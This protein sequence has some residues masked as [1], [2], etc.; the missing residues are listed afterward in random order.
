M[1]PVCESDVHFHTHNGTVNTA[2]SSEVYA[3]KTFLIDAYA[4]RFNGRVRGSSDLTSK[5][6]GLHPHPSKVRICSVELLPLVVKGK[7]IFF[8]DAFVKQ[9]E[10]SRNGDPGR[11]LL[12]RLRNVSHHRLNCR[13]QANPN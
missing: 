9:I 11:G 12:T 3:Q 13:T 4:H 8:T 7:S 6:F 10:Q 5:T 1:G 2:V